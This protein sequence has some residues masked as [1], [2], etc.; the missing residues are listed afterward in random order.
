MQICIKQRLSQ[1]GVTHFSTRPSAS[2]S[3]GSRRPELIHKR[4]TVRAHFGLFRFKGVQHCEQ[5]NHADLVG[6]V[7]R[8]GGPLFGQRGWGKR[9]RNGPHLDPQTLSKLSTTLRPPKNHVET[10]HM[11]VKSWL[12]DLVELCANFDKASLNTFLM[13]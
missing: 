4:D 1:P 2:L 7:K 3:C 11:V 5:C 8:L 12:S 10:S 13:K 6:L 9:T